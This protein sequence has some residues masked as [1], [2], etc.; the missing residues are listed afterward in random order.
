MNFF[1]LRKS[2]ET[3]LAENEPCSL[4][5]ST[6]SRLTEINAISIPEKNAESSNMQM[7]MM[8]EELINF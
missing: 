2:L 4:S 8:M 6:L 1:L 5:S 3:K 7:I